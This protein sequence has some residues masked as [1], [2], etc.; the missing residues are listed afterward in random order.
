MKTKRILFIVLIVGALLLIPLIAMQ[1]SDE[2]VWDL[3]D[4]LVV[5]ILLLGTGFLI[6][7][8]LRKVSTTKNRFIICG[9]IF[10]VLFIIWAELA[11]GL[12]GS[13]FAGS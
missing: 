8:V 10:A 2:V 5:G 11:V 4:F 12:F 13:P 7:L 1:F 9:V 3:F 6:D